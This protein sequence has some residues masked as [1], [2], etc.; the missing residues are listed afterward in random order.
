M[1]WLD[2]AW[3]E[4]GQKEESGSAANP[5][6]I[7]YFKETGGEGARI[8]SDEVAWCAAF[9]VRCLKLAGIDISPIPESER[10]LA[11]GLLKLGT[12]I[13][14]PRVGA[15]C[16]L[17]RGSDPSQGHVGFVVG[18]TETDVVLLGG[19]QANSVST[20]HFPRSRI[21]GMR[22]PETVTQSQVDTASDIAATA[23]A[24]QADTAKTGVANTVN[25][26]LPALPEKLPAPDAMAHSASALKSTI[27][28]G[29]DFSTFAYSK[30]WWVVGALSIYWILRIA[31]NSN[32]IR[33][34]RHEDAATGVQPLP[35]TTPV[36]PVQ[37]LPTSAAL[38][39]V[40]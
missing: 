40:V 36:A 37:P 39:G 29:I 17:S 21:R 14:E 27:E 10:L 13:D 9:A 18:S 30:V 4:L 15:V 16:V 38:Q 35:T 28:T 31:W 11:N 19:N 26:M 2:I 3:K 8:L 5:Q 6:I 32:W 25:Q 22:W 23:K 33:K 34:W 1:K 24:I 7:S 20:A 12:P